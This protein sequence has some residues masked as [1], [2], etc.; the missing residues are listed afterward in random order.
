MLGASGAVNAITT[1]SICAFPSSTILIMGI[2]PMPAYIAGAIF[3]LR[4]LWGATS[5]GPS[6]IG[7]VAHLGGAACG[8]L[9]F[10]RFRRSNMHFRRFY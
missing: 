2:I 1:F 8:A 3:V 10:T 9:Y 7:H 5:S 6:N 4:D